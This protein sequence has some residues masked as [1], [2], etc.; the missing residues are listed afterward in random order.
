M[1]SIKLSEKE[2]E[3]LVKALDNIRTEEETKG[4]NAK[5]IAIVLEEEQEK[6]GEMRTIEERIADIL[7]AMGMRHSLAGYRY[8]MEAI[9]LLQ[10]KP[11]SY[12]WV[13]KA[14]YP[15]IAKK[16]GTTSSGVERAMRHSIEDA[17]KNGNIEIIQYFFR[18][19]REIRKG[20]P[21]N[22][23]FLYVIV[24]AINMKKDLKLSY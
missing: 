4:D 11:D 12:K 8:N 2:Y 24:D 16:F 9:R 13:T 22:A 7:D 14:L 17:F 5:K 20:K 1:K 23:E 10:E 18:G 19:G 3:V 15:D 6:H 21:T